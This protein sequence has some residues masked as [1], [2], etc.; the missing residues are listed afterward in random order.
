MKKVLGT[1]ALG[2]VVAASTATQA[3]AET[4][5]RN[6]HTTSNSDTTVDL[7]TDVWDNTTINSWFVNYADK[8][9]LD[10][11]Y[12]K[13]T[14]KYA[15]GF[16]DLDLTGKAKGNIDL[17]VT[18]KGKGELVDPDYA[19][20]K[21]TTSNDGAH[22][23]AYFDQ[24]T[25]NYRNFSSYRSTKT[26]GDHNHSYKDYFVTGGDVKTD[27]K[28]N[29]WGEAELDITDA[30]ASGVAIFSGEE[31][32]TVAFDQFT[33]HKAGALEWGDKVQTINSHTHGTIVTNSWSDTESH[34]SAS[35][36]R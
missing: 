15:V 9:Y 13:T 31:K 32:E 5:V 19:Y 20:R 12:T 26:S 14:D 29:A 6:T 16:L 8:I 28:G 25:N 27:V 1:L 17:K 3:V 34:E 33:V 18:G 30:K 23:H 21:G 36:V 11:S 7:D 22:Q 24:D 35:G 4:Y 2:A 10:G